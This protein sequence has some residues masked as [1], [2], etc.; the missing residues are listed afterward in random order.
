MYR[1]LGTSLHWT[2]QILGQQAL[3]DTRSLKQKSIFNKEE[4]LVARVQCWPLMQKGKWYC[5][6]N[7]VL[8]ML[9]EFEF[10]KM[11][12]LHA[13]IRTA[14]DGIFGDRISSSW[15]LEKARLVDHLCYLCLVFF[16]VFASVHCCFVVTCW[17]KAYFLALFVMFNCVLS[18]SNV[19]SWVRC[20]TWLYRLPIYAAF[21]NF[22][23]A[24]KTH[25]C[26]G[27]CPFYGGVFC[28]CWS[29]V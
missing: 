27:C 12:T 16:H 20:G 19:V 9:A 15:H 23:N 10:L 2:L 25:G 26:F 17:E 13:P 22:L 3:S 7:Y 5:L 8:L 14:G 11:L 6:S 28:Y 29:I 18:L 4:T 21:L 24:F 1:I